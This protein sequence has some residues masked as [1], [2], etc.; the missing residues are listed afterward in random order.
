[1]QLAKLMPEQKFGIKQMIVV[2]QSQ[3]NNGISL[4]LG[5]NVG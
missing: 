4:T 1:M 5:N 2:D 3:A